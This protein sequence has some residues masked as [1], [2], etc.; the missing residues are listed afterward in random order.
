MATAFDRYGEALGFWR[1]PQEQEGDEHIDLKLMMGDGKR[2]RDIFMDPRNSK[3]RALLFK[4]FES[5][6][7]E[8]IKRDYSHI[9]DN[10]VKGYIEMN[11]M[12]LFESAQITFRFTT[13]AELDKS[14]KEVL[15]ETKNLIEGA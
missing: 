10:N 11:A 12:K 1:L 8:L 14:K 4:R 5:F 7:F 15:K 6:M 9:E 13:Q 2:L 3:D